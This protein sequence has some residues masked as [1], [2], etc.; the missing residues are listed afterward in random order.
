MKGSNIEYNFNSITKKKYKDNE[1]QYYE[2]NQ[3]LTNFDF[4]YFT[5][6]TLE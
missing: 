4:L 5:N 6:I 3:K 2:V 1:V